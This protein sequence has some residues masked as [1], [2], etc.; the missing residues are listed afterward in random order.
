MVFESIG[1][2]IAKK[3]LEAIASEGVKALVDTHIR[4]MM[5]RHAEFKDKSYEIEE[6]L[7]EY[8]EITYKKA[9]VM[10]TIVFRGVD[11]TLCDLYIPLS[12]V[13]DSQ[14]EDTEIICID[15]RCLSGLENNNKILIVDTAGMGK[16]TITKF[17]IIKYIIEN[18]RIPVLVELRKVKTGT[19][20]LDYIVKEFE[21]LGKNID[22][23]DIVKMLRNGEFAIFLDGYDEVGNEMKGSVMD[24]IQNFMTKAG[25]NQYMI[26]SREEA[27]LNSL[28]DFKRFSIKPLSIEEAFELIRLYDQ[29]GEL[30]RR[31]IERIKRDKQLAILKEFLNN[32]LLTSLLYKTFQYKEEIAYKKLDFYSQ[33]YEALFNDHDKIKGGAYVHE[34]MCLLDS[35]D[36]ERLLR[37]VAFISLKK[38]IVEY[39][40]KGDFVQIIQEAIKGMTWINVK[41]DDVLYDVTHAVPFF[42]KDGV[43]Y[44]WVHKSFMEYFAAGFIC[45]E[46]STTE[47]L[48]KKMVQSPNIEYYINVLDFCCEV[49]PEVF[50]KTVIYPFL[51]E[52]INHYNLVY[53]KERYMDY[54]ERY[55]RNIKF[56]SFISRIKAFVY[57]S[58]EDCEEMFD[59]DIEG[60]YL[61]DNDE[62]GK[63]RLIFH[64]SGER[65]CLAFAPNVYMTIC[66]LLDKKN[67]DIFENFTNKNQLEEGLCYDG[68][69]NKEYIIDD[70]EYRWYNS[71]KNYKGFSMMWRDG[72]RRFR[73]KNTEILNYEKCLQLKNTIKK[74]IA[75]QNQIEI[76]LD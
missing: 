74:E 75:I 4:P 13:N 49:K 31:L 29:N 11:K 37:R 23:E 20:I 21:L 59:N 55:L 46:T 25:S 65:M 42:Q 36:F 16:S 7:R 18:K 63:I 8:L 14:G 62:I 60:L 51:C 52:Y 2:L 9:M 17:L 71:K 3:G 33:V 1:I 22:A 39:Q 19:G 44:K 12:I 32:A 57:E 47:R 50:R 69:K 56:L 26:T 68:A 5:Q 54:D 76:D 73:K 28:G 48:L 40:S 45:Y 41:A 43:S 61:R 34:K 6:C 58:E 38:N 35:T 67:I 72:L 10:N 15:D 27:D 53:T 30:S 24:E 66:E 70:K 64:R